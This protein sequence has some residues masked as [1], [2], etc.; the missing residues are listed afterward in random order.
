[1]GKMQVAGLAPFDRARVRYLSSRNKKLRIVAAP[2][3]T[4]DLYPNRA[5]VL[6][7][8]SRIRFWLRGSKEGDWNV[9]EI[10]KTKSV[11]II[12][13]QGMTN[14]DWRDLFWLNVQELWVGGKKMKMNL[15]GECKNFTKCTL[16]GM[17]K[18]EGF[19]CKA[20]RKKLRFLT[21]R[22]S[23]RSGTSPTG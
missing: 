12:P 8:P 4:G 7:N 19:K 10:N 2:D 16:A 15:C 5:V 14:D 21:S 13:I 11:V 6:N 3:G 9:D 1:M 23:R 17:M 18:E 22:K 20:Q